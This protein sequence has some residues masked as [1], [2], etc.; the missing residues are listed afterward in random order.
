MARKIFSQIL[1]DVQAA[2]SPAD[3]AAILRY[4]DTPM[5]RT[6]LKDAF[7]PEVVYDTE[8]PSYRENSE[9][10]GY[11]SNNLY[12]EVRRLYIFKATE[13]K[14]APK[15]KSQL[16]AQVLES[17]D[18]SD[19]AALVEVMTQKLDKYGLTKEIVNMAFPNLV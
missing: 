10:D 11:A 13:K 9:T 6:L 3:K 1:K 18:A 7:S 14:V 5:L 4:H 15:R 2:E 19:A 16:L 8:I 17:I 12:V